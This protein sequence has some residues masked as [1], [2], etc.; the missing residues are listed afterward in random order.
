VA[1]ADRDPIPVPGALRAVTGEDIRM[2][3]IG[4]LT[5]K[6]PS[7]YG[8]DVSWAGLSRALAAALAGD[9]A[10]FAV[11]PAADVPHRRRAHVLLHLALRQDRDRPVPRPAEGSGGPGL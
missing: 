5:F 7:I 2:G 10:R 11:A 8:P 6:E 3:A 1:G 4:M 9:A